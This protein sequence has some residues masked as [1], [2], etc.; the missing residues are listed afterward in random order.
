MDLHVLNVL[1]TSITDAKAQR[2][3]RVIPKGLL[4]AVVTCGARKGYRNA[5]GC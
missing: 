1:E 4:M 5:N 3:A 2:E